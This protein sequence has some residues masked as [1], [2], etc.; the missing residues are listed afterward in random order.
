MT[1]MYMIFFFFFFAFKVWLVSAF[2]K[3]RGVCVLCTS[4]MLFVFACISSPG[5]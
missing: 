3:E 5:I 4:S 1:F 2:S